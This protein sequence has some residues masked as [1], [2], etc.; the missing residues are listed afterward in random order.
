MRGFFNIFF[1]LFFYYDIFYCTHSLISR[2]P[3]TGPQDN[4]P[5]FRYV[6]YTWAHTETPAVETPLARA[7]PYFQFPASF[8]ER[9]WCSFFN[10]IS[11]FIFFHSQRD[12]RDKPIMH[13]P[14]LC[15]RVCVCACVSVC[16]LSG[17]SLQS[18]PTLLARTK[19]PGEE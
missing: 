3:L 15:G 6:H 10:F 12:Y 13:D 9:T 14:L 19:K 1:R 11:G 5:R 18:L 2:C 8:N 7:R 16:G 4:R 17:P